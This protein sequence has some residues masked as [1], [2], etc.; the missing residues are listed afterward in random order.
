M[1]AE[2]PGSPAPGPI[3]EPDPDPDPDPRFVKIFAKPAVM[4]RTA[5]VDPTTGKAYVK[6]FVKPVT[7]ASFKAGPPASTVLAGKTAT[8]AKEPST[9]SAAVVCSRPAAARP[10]AKPNLT[11]SAATATADYCSRLAAWLSLP[12]AGTRTARPPAKP[13]YADC[14]HPLSLQTADYLLALPSIQLLAP[15]AAITSRK[16]RLRCCVV[17]MD[18]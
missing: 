13:N 10:P 11:E 16:L 7:R 6:I 9:A 1:S 5:A 17:M 4:P 3:L 14:D 2:T 8:L 12:T 15:I 18:V